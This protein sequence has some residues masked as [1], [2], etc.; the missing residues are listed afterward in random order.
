MKERMDE[1]MDGVFA[2]AISL[3]GSISGEHGIGTAKSRYLAMELD[4]ATIA[5]MKAIKRALDPD[6]IMNPGKI[7][8]DGAAR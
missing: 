2:A 6:N 8:A 7:F 4:G 3:K 1:I 5:A